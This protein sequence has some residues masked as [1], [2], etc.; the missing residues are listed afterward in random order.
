MREKISR[1]LTAGEK[2]LVRSVFGDAIDCSQV[3]LVRGKWWPFQ[4]RRSAMAPMG[5]IYFHPDG[6]G[7]SEDFS[8]ESLGAQG[9]FIHEMTHVWQAQKGGRFYLPLARHP[10]CKYHYDFVPGRP[11]SRYGLEQQ[12]EI[13][14]HIFM[15]GNGAETACP[16]LSILPFEGTLDARS[17]PN[18]G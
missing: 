14:R 1:S 13:V 17:G 6:G 16:P 12:A 4:P 15:A 2:A 10:F 5:N 9:F 11:F 18:E 8:K 3:K 7:W